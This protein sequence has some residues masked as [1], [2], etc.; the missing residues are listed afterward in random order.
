M[1]EIILSKL[2][3]QK[4]FNFFFNRNK[5]IMSS[6]IYMTILY[7]VTFAYII[8]FFTNINK[9]ID[10]FSNNSFGYSSFMIIMLIVLV[11]ISIYVFIQ[12][13]KLKKETKFS[14]DD[15][16]A[17][18]Y[19]V[20]STEKITIDDN[21]IKS[22]NSSQNHAFYFQYNDIACYYK[23]K[24][25]YIFQSKEDNFIIYEANKFDIK[26]LTEL[27]QKYKLKRKIVLKSYKK[28]NAL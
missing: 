13:N 17:K 24:D 28:D 23:Y 14:F 20:N 4:L 9:V 8:V 26:N 6:L 2:Y 15:E 1:K 21:G 12:F 11:A 19:P 27:I 18:T 5:K 3:I 16:I 25:L 7:I 10:G 22:I